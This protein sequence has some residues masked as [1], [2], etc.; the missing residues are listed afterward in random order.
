MLRTDTRVVQTCR[1]A[2]RL[3]DLTVLILKE[4]AVCAVQDAGRARAA[5]GLGVVAVRITAS[6]ALDAELLDIR[7]VTEIVERADGVAAAADARDEVVG[8]AAKR[9]L[10]LC[11]D[12]L[13]DDLLEVAYHLGIRMRTDRRTDDIVGVRDVRR[14]VADRLT[15]RIFERTRAA[16]HGDD[17]RPEEAHTEHV[18]P[19]TFDVDRAHEDVALHAEECSDRRRRDTVLPRTR[20]RDNVLLAHTLGEESLSECVVDLVCTRMKEVFTF[21]I[22]ICLAVVLRQPLGKVEVRRTPR[23]VAQI[24]AKLREEIL[25]R[26]V[27]Q[28]CRLEFVQRGHCNFGHIL[29]A[30]VAKSSLLTH[31]SLLLY[32]CQFSRKCTDIGSPHQSLAHKNALTACPVHTHR[33]IASEN[34]ALA[35]YRAVH[36]CIRQEV[37]RRLNARL[38]RH[39]IAVVDANELCRCLLCNRKVGTVMHFHEGIHA[40]TPCEVEQFFQLLGRKDAHDEENRIR[41]KGACLVD[42]IR[43]NDEVLAQER[44]IHTRTY[45][46]KVLVAPQKMRIGVHGEH[47]RTRRRVEIGKLQNAV[48]CRQPSLCGRL[49]F[50]LCYEPPASPSEVLRHV[51]RTAWE[52]FFQL[53]ERAAFLC[54][55][56]DGALFFDNFG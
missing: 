36:I 15:R 49:Q 28:T 6:A 4:I 41:A 34:T 54:L 1:D 11:A 44:R 33:I 25:I 39:E 19:L 42:L 9:I 29:P 2:V 38:E 35:D 14:P 37:E 47:S 53:I 51:E 50:A 20:L 3:D 27:F 7:I 16:R 12:L 48:C 26:T 21:Q 52:I 30:V 23:I 40:E 8:L 18:E 46:S 22:D 24:A 31:I 43:V 45:R 55:R 13:A 5:E 32:V 17:R 10:R 56:Y